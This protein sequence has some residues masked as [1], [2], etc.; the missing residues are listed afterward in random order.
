MHR[1]KSPIPAVAGAAAGVVDPG[2]AARLRP[3]LAQS[4]P[5]IILLRRLLRAWPAALS[6]VVLVV[7][8]AMAVFAP[9]V[10][11]KDPNRGDLRARLQPPSAEY[12]LGTDEQGRDMATRVIYGGRIA[13]QV[14]VFA[15]L[16]GM[17]VGTAMGLVSGYYGGWPDTVIMRLT[18]VLLAF[19]YILLVIAIV[20]ILGPDIQNAMIAIGIRI[21]PE[22]ARLVRSVVLSLRTREYVLA[23]RSIGCSNAR[24]IVR[25]ILPNCTAPIIVLA[26]LAL[27]GAILAEASLSFLGLGAQPPAPSWGSMVARGGE[28][29]VTHPHLSLVPG[30]A[31]ML[32]VYALNIF[33]DW[34]R[35]VLDPQTK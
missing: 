5:T 25:H 9:W 4:S 15:T 30:L 20:S 28:Y 22:F 21:I 14:G 27:A 33:G 26:T 11:D 2:T 3:N 17:I 24:I 7:V 18:D 32:V 16:L 34:L 8:V 13:L 23:A 29:L 6:L 35:D 1:P 31:I 10:T 19:P 12:V